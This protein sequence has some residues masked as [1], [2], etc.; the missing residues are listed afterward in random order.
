MKVLLNLKF[1]LFFVVLIANF[2]GFTQQIKVVNIE[3]KKGIENVFVYNIS[4]TLSAISDTN[5]MVNITI[6]S[7]K[8]TLIFTH[9]TY[10]TFTIPKLNVANVISLKEKQINLNPVEITAAQSRDKALE[11]ISKIDKIDARTVLLNN[12]QT[13]ADLLALSG[14]VYI[15]KSQMGGGSPV[16]R[17]FEANRV[18]LVVDGVRL[19]NAIYRSGH[20][21]NV[22]TIDNAILEKTD[23][24]YGA[25]SVIYGSDAIGGVVD[26]H[27]KT[28]QFREKN[29]SI[30]NN[31]VSNYFRYSTANQEKTAHL[32]FNLGGKKLASLTSVT[33]SNYGDLTMGKQ[34]NSSYPNFG[35]EKYYTKRINNKDT[36]LRKDDFYKQIGTAYSQTDVLQKLS[37]KLS[38]KITLNLNTQYSTTS[39]IPRYDRL[40]DYKNDKLK[41]IEWSY[42]PQNRLLTSLSTRIKADNKWFNRVDLLAS[43]QKIEEERITRRFGNNNRI[44][45]NEAVNVYG[46]NANF[47]KLKH[48]ESEWFYGAELT[49][50]TVA[51]SAFSENI[52]TSAKSSASTRYPD[53]GSTLSNVAAY[54]SYKNNFSEHLTF[55]VG[56]R[57]NYS[58][59]KLAFADT[60]FVK[61]PFKTTTINNGALTGSAGM[62]Y[63]PSEKW[64]IRMAVSTAFRNPNVDDAG[65]VFAKRDYVM[66]P[67]KN[68][69]PEYAYNGEIG[70]TRSFY[71]DNIK[72]NVLGFYTILKNA[73][74]RDYFKF[75]DL[76]SMRYEGEMLKIQANV[77]T[78]EAIVY[79]ASV[80]IY[81]KITDEFS[82]K[83]SFNYTVG[84][85]TVDNVP[86][87][88]IPPLYGRTDFIIDSA[89]FIITFYAEYQA[90]KW[91]ADYSPY[92]EDNADKA[93]VNG[94]PAWQTFNMSVAIKIRKSFM[95]QAALENMLDTNYRP[96][97]SSV[98]AAGRNFI[99][100]FRANI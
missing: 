34:Q 96:F 47:I 20:L 33:F 46:F 82:F 32:D 64:K 57:Y 99:I 100:T 66:V 44:T 54:V 25:N 90:W 42:G 97:S 56:A 13:S 80:N 89:P 79:G 58:F 45:R 52:V 91:L 65:K 62:L 53:N 81:G 73:I 29:D 5:G 36:M 43:Y 93:T 51:S 84:K 1:T 77:N 4:K 12:P 70:I 6:F 95:L 40:T 14:G 55:D 86:M 22:I 38:K 10:K 28:P 94:T 8:D 9:Q 83:S 11:V 3:T 78:S 72:L 37:Y 85:N 61:L 98:S 16:I 49:H 48:N 50:N 19:N 75:N 69:I 7:K 88:H 24:I 26:F 87:A 39:N 35:I 67:N 23:V 76:D 27:T 31:S 21:Q 30:N 74:V 71:G 92:G 59:L 68:L 41:W 60:S 18:L 63:H 2:D 17:G 15:Q